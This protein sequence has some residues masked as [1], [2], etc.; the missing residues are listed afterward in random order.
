M[1]LRIRLTRMGAKKQP[2]YR[3]IVAD[4][5]SPRDGRFIERVG[6]YNPLLPKEGGKRLNLNEDRVKFWLQRGAKPSDRV[7]RFLGQASIIPAPKFTFGVNKAKKK[8]EAA[9][10]AKAEKAD[11]SPAA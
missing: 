1:A 4:S 8:A 3:I 5:R 10:K 9:A 2:S 11:A 7:A 6:T